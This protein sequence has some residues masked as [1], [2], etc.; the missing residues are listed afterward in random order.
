VLLGI[1]P[2][3]K[4]YFTFNLQP[5][6]LPRI[7][8][9]SLQIPILDFP[10]I[11]KVVIKIQNLFWAT[12]SSLLSLRLGQQPTWPDGHSAWQA[13][14]SERTLN[15]ASASAFSTLVPPRLDKWERQ[16]QWSI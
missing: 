14:S 10:E 8:V 3:H 5:K 2:W 4:K 6:S 1:Y 15:A 16:R 13:A 7:Q 9:K 11:T 12:F